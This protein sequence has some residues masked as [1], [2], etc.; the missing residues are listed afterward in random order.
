MFF[1]GAHAKIK[2][3]DERVVARADV[4]K[5][6][7][8][9]IDIFQHFCCRFAM[10]AVKAVNRNAEAPMLIAL[11]FDHVVLRLAEKPML[12]T[13]ERRDSKKIAVMLLK[14]ARSVLELR[15]NRGRMQQGR[16]SRAAKLLRPKL[17]KI[18]EWKFDA[19]VRCFITSCEVDRALRAQC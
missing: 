6:D 3:P 8:Q 1:T 19:H 11:P 14:N 4:L 16:D 10:F 13:E 5:I 18:V 15:R 12:R 17:F 9:N 2:R 7:K